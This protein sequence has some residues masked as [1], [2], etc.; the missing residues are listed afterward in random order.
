[1]I[2]EDGI[3]VVIGHKPNERVTVKFDYDTTIIRDAKALGQKHKWTVLQAKM[4]MDGKK[5]D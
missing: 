3:Y 2:G 5:W 4:V 1:M